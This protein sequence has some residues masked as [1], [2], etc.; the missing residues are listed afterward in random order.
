[1][2]RL[3]VPQIFTLNLSPSLVED[4]TSK[5]RVWVEET[6]APITVIRT[7]KKEDEAIALADHS[8]SG[9]CVM[10]QIF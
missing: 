9:R 4:L 10:V 6:F 5:M 3:V 1:M 7:Y 2:V 8:S